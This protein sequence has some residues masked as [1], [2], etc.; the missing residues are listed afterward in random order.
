[1]SDT[2]ERPSLQELWTQAGGGTGSYD[3]A[4]YLS[5]MREHGH[6]LRDDEPG[7]QYEWHEECDGPI[8][9]VCNFCMC[10]GACE[11][12]AG[13]KYTPAVADYLSTCNRIWF[14]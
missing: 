3:A 8:C 12:D 1:M 11:C 13:P 2:D 6:V 4:R 5:L 14:R 9:Q 10:M 7:K